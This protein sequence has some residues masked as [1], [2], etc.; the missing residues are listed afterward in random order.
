[1]K[2]ESPCRTCIE[3]ILYR[4][5]VQFIK[6]LQNFIYKHTIDSQNCT[7]TL[8]K[9]GDFKVCQVSTN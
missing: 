7:K 3:T 1:M 2:D 8:K 4:A 6:T 9:K 5:K